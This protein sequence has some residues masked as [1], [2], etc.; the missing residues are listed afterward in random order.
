MGGG[1]YIVEMSNQIEFNWFYQIL[2]HINVII[3]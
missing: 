2:D 1:D 3:S